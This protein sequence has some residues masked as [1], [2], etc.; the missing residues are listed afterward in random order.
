M[1]R[2]QFFVATSLLVLVALLTAC[3]GTEGAAGAEGP[4][5]PPGPAGPE[6][7]QGP[8]GEAAATTELT[9]VECHNDT[10]LITGK[11]TAWEESLHGSGTATAYAGGRAG[12]A[13]CHSG[14]GFSDWLVAGGSPDDSAAN[15]NPTRQDCRACHNI[16]TSYTGEDW[17]LE[18]TDAVALYAFEDVTFDG[19]TGNLCVNCHQPRR[20][21]EAVDGIVNVNSTH[22]GPHHGPQSAMLL[23]IGGAG[24][25]E[26]KPAAHVSMVE[27]TCVSCH[28]VNDNHTFDPNVSACVECHADA[29][30]FDINGLQT[31]VTAMLEELHA[32]LIAK[33]LL[34]ADGGIVVGE[35][36]EAEAAALWNYIY[37]TEEDKSLG[38]H[39]PSYVKALLEASLA[40]LQ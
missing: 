37:I 19:G 26:G 14:N 22:W 17:S 6:G 16:H 21:F 15:P 35:Y 28:L 10:S 4:A 7:P 20:Q 2:K 12:C 18:T 40:A 30:N 24:A 36:P 5:G 3:A 11:E 32:A 34:D 33:G 8:A 29:E 38:V 1:S 27:N 23:G 9:C 25:V 13:A 39:N 31:E